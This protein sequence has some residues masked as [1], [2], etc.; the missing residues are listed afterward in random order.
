MLVGFVARYVRSQAV[1]EEIVQ[2]LFLKLWIG[3]EG[4]PSVD[5]PKAYLYRAARN[6]ALN[7]MRREGLE[8]GWAERSGRDEPAFVAPAPD[9]A[10]EEALA[11]AVR[12]AIDALPTRCRLIFTMSRDDR[13]TYAEIAGALGLSVKTVETQMG[14][15][16][17]AL[18]AALA[19]HL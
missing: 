13:L 1:G 4:L 5:S 10:D 7:H 8:R 6:A 18:R 16:L 12:A 2:D 15:A 17:K 14:R 3:R 9:V 11:A 19:S